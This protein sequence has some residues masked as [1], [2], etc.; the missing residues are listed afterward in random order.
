LAFTNA[1]H[2]RCITSKGG[3]QFASFPLDYVGHDNAANPAA[4]LDASTTVGAR[5]TVRLITASWEQIASA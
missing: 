4:S 3:R 5:G 1:V 2:H